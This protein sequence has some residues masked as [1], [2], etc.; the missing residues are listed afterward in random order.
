MT[1]QRRNNLIQTAR[2]LIVAALVAALALGG[3]GAASL[4]NSHG[5]DGHGAGHGMA[6]G[7]A[8]HGSAPIPD[9][10]PA[11]TRAYREANDRMHGAMA[12]AFTGDADVDFARGMIPHHQGAIDMARVVLEH[13]EDPEIRALAEAIVTA[14]EEEIAFLEAWLAEHAD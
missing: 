13:G 6:H 11:S 14:Q 4:A 2:P 3:W 5:H 8:H 9:D 12:I 1:F 7:D 10:A